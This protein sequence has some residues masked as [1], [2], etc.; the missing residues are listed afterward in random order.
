VVAAFTHGK[1]RE[2]V[3]NGEVHQWFDTRA[4]R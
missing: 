4:A 1:Y 3:A 2:R